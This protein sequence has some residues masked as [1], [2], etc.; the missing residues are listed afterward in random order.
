VKIKSI[1][2]F[3]IELK[4]NIKTTPRVPKSKNP[5]DMGGMVS[6]MKRYPNISRSDF[7]KQELKKIQNLFS[8]NKFGIK[9][10]LCALFIIFG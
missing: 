3:T 1:Q 10:L 7:L 5:F 2:A 9:K 8:S 6:P 4:P